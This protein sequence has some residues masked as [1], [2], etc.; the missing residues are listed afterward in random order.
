MRRSAVTVVVAAL[1]NQQRQLQG[2]LL[3]QPRIDRGAI[4]PLQVSIRQ[5]PRT[6][7]ALGHIL[8]GQLDMH[9]AQVR[10]HF[11]VNAERKVDF[12]EDVLEATGLQAPGAGLGVAVHGITPPQH[13]L[14]GLAN[15]LD[16]AWQRLLD[17]LGAKAMYEGQ[18]TRLVLRIQSRHQALRPRIIHAATDLDGHRVRNAAEVFDV[19]AITLCRAH[20]DPRIVRRQV[21]PALLARNETRL[22][23]LVQQMQALM[24]AIEVRL[25]RLMDGAATDAFE[26]IERIGNRIGN[27]LVGILQRAVVEETQIPILRMMQIGK[28]AIDERP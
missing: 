13:A 25:G 27:T 24:A 18:T 7:G 4:S 22:R 2:L 11:P 23:L 10:P 20:A 28:T 8:A 26:K 6:T 1:R 17:I 12:L 5:A 15:S 16:Q 14:T 9:A 19:R 21:V 3:V